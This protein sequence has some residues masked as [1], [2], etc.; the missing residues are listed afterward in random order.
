MLEY[1]P[2][3]QL[4]ALSLLMIPLLHASAGNVHLELTRIGASI[5]GRKSRSLWVEI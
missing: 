2:G 3:T 4:R 1:S 5:D